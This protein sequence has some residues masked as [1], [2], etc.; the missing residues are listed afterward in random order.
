M[1]LDLH[2]SAGRSASSR[3]RNPYFGADPADASTNW[4]REVSE[5]LKAAAHEG[6]FLILTILTH[7]EKSVSELVKAVELPQS[8]V[9][10][11]LARLRLGNLVKTRKDGRVVYYS[12]AGAEIPALVKIF[13]AFASDG[14]KQDGLPAA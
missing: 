14:M 11:H 7:G 5:I 3:H 10:W 2:P 9:S 1:E 6:R 8:V 4:A 13:S 12:L